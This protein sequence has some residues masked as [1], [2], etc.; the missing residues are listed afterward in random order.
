MDKQQE[1][2]RVGGMGKKEGS[3]ADVI[4][5]C[6]PVVVP[7][8]AWV[9]GLLDF[10]GGFVFMLVLLPIIPIHKDMDIQWTIGYFVVAC[11]IMKWMG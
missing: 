2:S 4:V 5:K 7:V 8:L 1:I 6:V 9:F 10:M 3:D 11:A